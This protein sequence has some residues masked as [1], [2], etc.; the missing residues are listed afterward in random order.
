MTLLWEPYSQYFLLTYLSSLQQHLLMVLNF[1][2][3]TVAHFLLSDC[4]RANAEHD[5]LKVNRDSS[6]KDAFTVQKTWRFQSFLTSK[7]LSIEIS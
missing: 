6:R 2:R 1:K 5:I 4:S 7:L 3:E